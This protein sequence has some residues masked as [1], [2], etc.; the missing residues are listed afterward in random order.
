MVFLAVVCGGAV[1]GLHIQILAPAEQHD[2]Y[3]T[4]GI[5]S[6]AKV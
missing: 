2:C 6:F 1:D 4:S 3:N 5:N